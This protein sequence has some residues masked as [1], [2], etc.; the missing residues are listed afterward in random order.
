MECTTVRP[1]VQC[2]FMSKK[3][4]TYIGG[5][6]LEIVE[7]CKGCARVVQYGGKEFCSVYPDPAARW[8]GGICNFATHVKR[9]SKKVEGKKINPLKAAKRA[10][11]RR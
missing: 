3:G 1:G 11:R 10:S 9:E 4:C 6:C 2:R 7:Q 8:R 5:V